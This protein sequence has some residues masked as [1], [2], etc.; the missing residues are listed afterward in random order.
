[1]P[2][3]RWLHGRAGGAAQLTGPA[4]GPI[5][6][7]E[8]HQDGLN[9][10][11]IVG[12]CLGKRHG[13]C[14]SNEKRDAD[15]PFEGGDDPRHRWLSIS[16]PATEKLLFLATGEKSCNEKSPSVIQNL[17]LTKS[18]FHSTANF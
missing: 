11:Q 4:S 10:R 7:F 1:M 12:T 2:L 3:R 15:R 5:F 13:S 16:R 17:Y 18:F 9:T 14:G 6:V 8:S